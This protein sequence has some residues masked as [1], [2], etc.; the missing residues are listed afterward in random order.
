MRHWCGRKCQVKTIDSKQ[1]SSIVPAIDVV[2]IFN[3]T[4]NVTH[5][6]LPNNKY[7]NYYNKS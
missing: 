2:A 3:R 5:K 4:Y 6:T 1:Y 7:S